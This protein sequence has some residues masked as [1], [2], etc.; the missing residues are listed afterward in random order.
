MKILYRSDKEKTT[1]KSIEKY[2]YDLWNTVS[3]HL[4]LQKKIPENGIEGAL[5]DSKLI[6]DVFNVL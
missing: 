2:R 6:T 4:I 3:K 5:L 1:F